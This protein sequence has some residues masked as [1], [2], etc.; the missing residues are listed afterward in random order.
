MKTIKGPAVFLAQFA[1]DDAPFNSLSG[2]A[3]WAAEKGFK[4]V[5]IPSW[6]HRLIDLA[7][8]AESQTY[9]DE[10]LG[11]L[12]EHDLQLTDLASHLQGQLVALHPAFDLPAD[13]FAPASLRNDPQARQQWATEQ[14]Y[15]AARA[16]RRLGLEKHVTFSGTLLWPFLYPYPQWPEG[17]IDEGFNEL[18]RRWTPILNAFDEQGIDLCYEIH[19]TEDLHDGLTFER[20]LEKTH[21]HPRCNIMYDPSHLVLQGIDYLTYIDHYHPRIKA[22]HVK[23][24]EFRPNG[25]TGAY[26]GYQSWTSR[27][28]RFRS[29][30]DGQ[31]DFSGIFSKLT[32]YGFDGWAV[33]E[34]ECCFKN[35]EDGAR[36]GA[37]FISDHIIRVTDKPFDD[38]CKSWADPS[39]NRKILGIEGAKHA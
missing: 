16:S 15:L 2:M 21:N 18:A 8:A 20:F 25:K 1:G 5:E 24:A 30:G 34:W 28:G 38:F 12:A 4:G 35:P 7:Q 13:S 6:D 23:D 26:G 33:L 11:V 9:A 37:Q 29:P 10:I 19:P 31:T 27:A 39:L 17:L 32:G 36:E 14:L 3:G 22:F